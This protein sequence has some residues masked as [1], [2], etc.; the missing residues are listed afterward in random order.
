[1]A[2]NQGKLGPVQVE[3]KA[4]MDKEIVGF[5]DKAMAVDAER[6]EAKEQFDKA[7]EDRNKLKKE[8]ERQEADTKIVGLLMKRSVLDAEKANLKKALDKHLAKRIEL[9]GTDDMPDIHIKLTK[10]EPDEDDDEE[11]D[12][13][14][15]GDDKD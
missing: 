5:V 12:D 10:P 11:E 2:K 6:H 4:K 1:M 15:E 14:E 7:V 9:F 8:K 13:E 3:R